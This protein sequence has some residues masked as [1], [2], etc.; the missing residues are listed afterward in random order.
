MIQS[1]KY[2]PKSYAFNRLTFGAKF[3]KE[4]GG[5]RVF[6]KLS[7]TQYAEITTHS[8]SIILRQNDLTEKVSLVTTNFYAS[9]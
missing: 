7:P 2:M 9:V 6:V 8:S 3:R 4:S 5:D 1:N